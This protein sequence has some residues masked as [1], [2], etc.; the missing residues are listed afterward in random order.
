MTTSRLLALLFAPLGLSLLAASP[1]RATV[2]DHTY[3]VHNCHFSEFSDLSACPANGY[4]AVP[5]YADTQPIFTLDRGKLQPRSDTQSGRPLTFSCPI[6]RTLSGASADIHA[7]VSGEGSGDTNLKCTLYAVDRTGL[8]VLSTTAELAGQSPG[9]IPALKL[10]GAGTNQSYNMRCEMPIGKPTLLSRT[11]PSAW[12]ASASL[13]NGEA[14][15]ALDAAGTSTRWTT[16]ANMANGQTFTVDMKSSKVFDQIVLDS[17]GNDYPRAFDVE[18][19]DNGTTF[20]KIWSDTAATDLVKISFS[21]QN[22]RYFRIK[23]TGSANRW[24]SIRDL[25]VYNGTAVNGTTT[26]RSYRMEESS[27]T[28]DL[29]VRTYPASVCVPRGGTFGTSKVRFHPDG[30]TNRDTA[31]VTIECPMANPFSS[32]T[33]RTG[34]VALSEAKSTGG[35]SCRMTARYLPYLNDQRASTS[36]SSSTAAG[37]FYWSFA[38]S[39]NYQDYIRFG[40][41]CTLTPGSTLRMVRLDSN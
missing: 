16:G 12:T 29:T 5:K 36:A 1:A 37:N 6:M 30:L 22:K 20:T 23:Q 17:T 8:P 19:S 28:T 7:Q 31:N 24:W 21:A 39:T 10:T 2:V 18:V 40:M 33:P 14:G 15:L 27:T 38:D 11:S 9:V 3:S 34:Y 35:S 13:N 26:L 25:N 41:T 4:C 32:S